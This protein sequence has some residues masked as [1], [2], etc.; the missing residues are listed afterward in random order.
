MASGK[1]HDRSITI[2]TPVILTTAIASGHAD[3]AIIATASYYLA[4]MYLSP[5]LDLVSR[6]Y[7]RWGLLRFIWLPY[8]RLIPRHR[9]WL[10]HGPAIGSL[11]RLLYLAAWLSPIWIFFPGLQ[12]IQ[13]SGVTA[14]NVAAFLVGVELS[15][16]NHL[17]LD[18]LLIPLPKSLKRRL[19]GD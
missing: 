18:G 14:P 9:H 1:V 15:A 19:K 13:W 3:V 4:G 10:S 11:V 7:K 8:Q 2:T 6:P 5:D 16:L 17:L 12:Q